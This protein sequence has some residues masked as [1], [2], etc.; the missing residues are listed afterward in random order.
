MLHFVGT[1]VKRT[2]QKA[3]EPRTPSRVSRRS[4]PGMALFGRVA[5]SFPLQDTNLYPPVP[6]VRRQ[7]LRGSATKPI[8]H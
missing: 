3:T 8:S 6:Y 4:Y 5:D 1:T 2:G 7:I